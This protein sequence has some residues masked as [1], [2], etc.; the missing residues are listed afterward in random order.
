MATTTSIELEN[1]NTSGFL[2]E[3]HG[4]FEI[5]PQPR[6][7]I[8]GGDGTAGIS[9]KNGQAVAAALPFVGESVVA[10]IHG[11][12]QMSRAKAS[13]VILL[14][15]GVNF[16]NTMG[17]G[18]L[19]VALPTI[20][21]DVG[22]DDTLLLWPASVYALAA[23]C[24][25]LLFGALGDVV[26]AKWIWV[27]GAALYTVFT[28][29]VGLCHTSAQLIGFRAV[30]GIAIAMCLPT[31]VSLTTGSFLA[32]RWRNYAFAIQGLGQPLGFSVGLISGGSLTERLSWRWGF[33][34]SAIFNAAL[35]VGAFWALPEPTHDKNRDLWKDLRR[36]IDWVGGLTI[37]TSLG[38]LSYVFS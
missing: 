16:L 28:L 22:L 36:K 17:S 11:R 37:S 1:L 19:T 26:G 3:S 38:L 5:H 12:Y 14:L 8:G 30:L 7:P 34:I 10:T 24:T 6:A 4:A 27:T 33:Y 18:I 20:A 35:V 29:A 2:V 23:G 15:A 31:A 32:G 21:H 9:V 13:L 25:L